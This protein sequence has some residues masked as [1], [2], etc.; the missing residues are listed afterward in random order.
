MNNRIINKIKFSS[1]SNEA[2]IF[3][4][5]NGWVVLSNQIEKEQI[6]TIIESWRELSTKFAVEIGCNIEDY[7]NVISQ[8][9]DLWKG[10]SVF[11]NLLQN[12]LSSLATTSFDLDGSRLLHDH[13]ICKTFD[14]ANGE[15]PWHQD[16]M[17]WPVDRTGMS[18]LMPLVNVPEEH[19]C[20]QVVSKTHLNSADQ[21]VDFMS[22]KNP[23][24]SEQKIVLLPT[25]LGDVILLH[26][27]TWHRSLPTKLSA[28]ERPVHI[29]LWVPE[30]TH[31]YPDNANW[32][33]LN[34]RVTVNKGE[35]LNDD[36]FPIFG[37]KST[38]VG[39]SYENIHDGV[40]ILFGMFNA[41]DT[42]LLEIQKY[43]NKKGD[44]TSLLSS[45]INRKNL[46]EKV[47]RKNPDLNRNNVYKVIKDVWISGAAY[48][49]HR[50]RNVFN[51]AYARWKE[52]HVR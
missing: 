22:A 34:E 28:N 33:P 12:N 15:I 37:C 8:W 27:R 50:S 42:V 35:L 32:H 52:I 41:K 6:Q 18:T 16:S 38:K 11:F 5:A 43:L 7:K 36:E 21:P 17:Y 46:L 44:I 47:L 4:H 31:Y 48:E 20:L 14:G 39:T 9:R 2:S 45:E 24:D 3:Y 10:D 25:Q 26:S 23:F 51:S 49:Q 30:Q 1:M 40:P 19:G 13:I 29:A